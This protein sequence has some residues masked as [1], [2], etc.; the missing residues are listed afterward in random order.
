MEELS[1]SEGGGQRRRRE[2]RETSPL[3]PFGQGGGHLTS[4]FHTLSREHLN[5]CSLRAIKDKV[6]ES[7][8]PAL[9][10]ENI[11]SGQKG[12][13]SLLSRS[14]FSSF[15]PSRIMAIDWVWLTD[16]VVTWIGY[17]HQLITSTLP[18]SREMKFQHFKVLMSRHG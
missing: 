9:P 16:S 2:G 7:P 14:R 12:A 15:T 13:P 18:V 4:H 3:P 8:P 6:N 1:V 11:I 10:A 5:R 17:T